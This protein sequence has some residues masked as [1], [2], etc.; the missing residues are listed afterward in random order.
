M[1]KGLISL[2]VPDEILEHFEYEG[3]EELSGVIRVHL[4]EKQDPNHYPKAILGKGIRF[5]NGYMN[6]IELQTFPT[7]GKEVFLLLKRRRWKLKGSNKSY[8]NNY[9][10]TEK[11]MKA[12]KEFGAF[13]K[14]IGRW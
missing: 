3:L 5:L 4:V 11:G 13:L 7:K 6:P 1:K 2:L 12:T 9:D 8:Y 14:E 10:F